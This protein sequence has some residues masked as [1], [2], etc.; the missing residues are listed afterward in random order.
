MARLRRTVISKPAW[1]LVD[2][3]RGA[4]RP[5]RRS[6]HSCVVYKDQ[7][8]VFGGTDGQYHYNDIWTF[9]TRTH[10]WSEFWVSGYVPSPREGHGAAIIDD[11]MYVFGGRGVDGA[12]IGE[13]VA[14]RISR[15]SPPYEYVAV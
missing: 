12:N 3:P 1:E 14:F 13:L 8:I 4:P 11:T 2:P 7:L 5:F 10:T 9:D 15:K 6:G